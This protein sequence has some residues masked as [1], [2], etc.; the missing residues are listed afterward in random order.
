MLK[1]KNLFK[2][3]Y[4]YEDFNFIEE[5]D[6]GTYIFYPAPN[7]KGYKVNSL[8]EFKPILVYW[9]LSGVFRIFF[10][11]TLFIVL[12]ILTHQFI[13]MDKLFTPM[14]LLL[15]LTS[16]L[17]SGIFMW[18]LRKFKK[19]EAKFKLGKSYKIT[20]GIIILLYIA[21]LIFVIDSCPCVFYDN[22]IKNQEWSRALNTINVYLKF[23]PKNDN[24][25]ENRALVRYYMNDVDGAIEDCNKAIEL[26]SKNPWTYSGKAYYMFIKN[27]KMTPEIQ[28]LFEKSIQLTDKYPTGYSDRGKVYF[29]LGESDKAIKD[30]EQAYL[31]SGNEYYNYFAAL[32]QEQKGDYCKA[33]AYYNTVPQNKRFEI[34]E[35]PLKK[36]YA[37]FMCKE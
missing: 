34:S 5:C 27:R 32:A 23:K 18:N 8:K 25:Y 35:L 22:S 12:I 33:F 11:I 26:N 19:V 37:K 4:D 17:M 3:I 16:C 21:L 29:L 10:I 14:I 31:H 7:S 20:L 24:L 28:S 9:Q 6:D 15:C 1:F 36:E 2:M 30:F 13:N